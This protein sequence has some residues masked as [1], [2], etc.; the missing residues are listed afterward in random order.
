MTSIPISYQSD[1]LTAPPGTRPKRFW[2]SS[3]NASVTVGPLV[4]RVITPQ[5]D[6]FVNYDIHPFVRSSSVTSLVSIAAIV[7]RLGW[8][9]RGTAQD[10][11]IAR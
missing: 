10:T 3:F 11:H 7:G 6:I 5:V 4:I 1:L 8:G 2:I 9:D